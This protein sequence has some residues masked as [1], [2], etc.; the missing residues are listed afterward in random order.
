MIAGVDPGVNGAVAIINGK[1]VLVTVEDLP[2]KIK[3]SKKH[4][5]L[6]KVSEMFKAYPIKVACIEQVAS[7]PGQGVAS[8]FKFGF[9]SG[10][11]QGLL[12]GIGLEPLLL[13]PSVW[14]PTLG[15]TTNKKESLALASK[16]FG[17]EHFKLLKDHNK[18][19]AA[20]IAYVGWRLS[21]Q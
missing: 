12:F 4:L 16:L 6:K 17:S 18:A 1:G 15:L 14:K 20:L 5:D 11:L 21:H 9:S 19:E 2:I 13:K 7:A 3:N 8:T 10:F